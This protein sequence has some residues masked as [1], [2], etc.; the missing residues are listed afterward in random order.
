[1]FIDN[2][3]VYV[4]ELRRGAMCLEVSFRS[5]GAWTDFFLTAAI[6]ILLLRSSQNIWLRLGHAMSV[7]LKLFEK[8]IPTEAQRSHRDAQILRQTT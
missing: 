8:T 2:E 1:M 3:D 4:S 7:L 5:Y 6:N